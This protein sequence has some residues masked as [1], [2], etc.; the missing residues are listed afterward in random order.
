MQATKPTV[1]QTGWLDISLTSQLAQKPKSQK[2]SNQVSPYAGKQVRRQACQI[3]TPQACQL[4]I[5]LS[6]LKPVSKPTSQQAN[7]TASPQASV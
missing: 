4:Y 5:Y 7:W 6:N 2:A 1:S 3:T